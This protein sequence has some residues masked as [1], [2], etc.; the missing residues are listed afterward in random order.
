MT[1]PSLSNRVIPAALIALAVTLGIWLSR[2]PLT[3]APPPV[4]AKAAPEPTPA[5][6]PIPSGP[7]KT[8]TTEARIEVEIVPPAPNAA[9]PKCEPQFRCQPR[10]RCLFRRR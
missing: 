3:A 2:S 6:L 1:R 8:N 7:P 4:S 5:P 9:G 10:R